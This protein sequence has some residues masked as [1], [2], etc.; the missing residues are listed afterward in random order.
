MS[1]ISSFFEYQK[2]VVLQ[3]D[4]FLTK[5]LVII[6]RLAFCI[7]GKRKKGC[8]GIPKASRSP[9]WSFFGEGPRHHFKICVQAKREKGLFWNTFWNNKSK[10]FFFL[11]EGRS[12]C[13]SK[14][15]LQKDLPFFI[16]TT[17]P[18][19]SH[20]YWSRC[21]DKTRFWEEGPGVP[22]SYSLFWKIRMPLVF[23]NKSFW[24][25]GTKR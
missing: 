20:F 5:D 15:K 2:Q 9:K 12:R 6:S 18:K 8:F 3:N 14:I 25:L 11:M 1:F 13:H 19:A 22:S 16:Q 10:A 4:P 7:Q 17:G 24:V 21:L 23:Q